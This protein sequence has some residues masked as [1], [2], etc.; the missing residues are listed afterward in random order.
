M[1]NILVRIIKS[2]AG[3]WSGE[4]SYD[5]TKTWIAPSIQR[6]LRW[7]WWSLVPIATSLQAYW[8]H[9]VEHRAVSE[10]FTAV[11][12]TAFYAAGLVAFVTFI[13]RRPRPG[14]TGRVGEAGRDLA[15][16]EPTVDRSA[17]KDLLGRAYEQGRALLKDKDDTEAVT[18]WKER[19]KALITA[20]FG[21][22]EANV[23]MYGSGATRLL[24]SD[25]DRSGLPPYLDGL[26]RFIARVETIAIR[27]GFL[28]EHWLVGRPDAPLMPLTESY[29]EGE[30]LRLRFDAD[31]VTR[32]L[33]I[34]VLLL[35]FSGIRTV[36]EAQAFFADG[37]TLHDLRVDA[38]PTDLGRR[39]APL[40]AEGYCA[41]GPRLH[42]CADADRPQQLAA[43]KDLLR[44]LRNRGAQ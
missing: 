14:R 1:P 21:E 30:L 5:A 29:V 37:R 2:V 19:T 36:E 15:A 3:E 4:A 13:V 24:W 43:L 12:S 22:T 8:T 23:F 39:S 9:F 33:S 31:D 17:L 7:L 6:A 20:A 28:L 42:Q 40:D 34:C 27:P 38:Y 35:R 10:V 18:K 25:N 11:L 26:M 41:W 16:W 32:K 44:A